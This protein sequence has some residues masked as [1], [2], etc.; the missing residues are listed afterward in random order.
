MK[1]F[2]TNLKTLAVVGVAALAVSCAEAYDDTDLRNEVAK[3]AERVQTLEDRWEE[4]VAALRAL[5]DEKVAL[6]EVKEDGAW[7]FTLSDGKTL[8]L[9]PEYAE[10][11]LTLITEG[12]VKYWAKVEGNVVTAL[13]DAQGNKVAFNGAPQ[14]Q[15]NAEGVVEVSVDG[16][17]SWIATEAKS[18]ISA[19]DVEENVA[20]VTLH[21]GE[22]LKFALYEQVN[23]NVNGHALFVAPASSEK[24]TMTLDGIVE[25]LP[26]VAPK[27]WSVEVDGLVVTVT[28]PTEV[29]EVQQGGGGIG[30]LSTEGSALGAASGAVKLLA[31]SKEGKSVVATLYV[32]A[33]VSGAQSLKVMGENLVITN[34]ATSTNRWGDV[35]PAAM[36]IVAF[37]AGE[38]T[39]ESFLAANQ[40]YSFPYGTYYYEE[41]GV[42]TVAVSEI[43]ASLC[44]VEK[45]ERGAAYT[46]LA[47]DPNA[48]PLEATGV[49][50][51]DYVATYTNVELAG[52]TFKDININV[53]VEGYD[54][55]KL[56][57]YNTKYDAFPE[58]D[59]Q[60]W[61]YY[62]ERADWGVNMTSNYS[63]SIFDVV[64]DI[65]ILAN[66]A[67]AIYVLPMS[68][69]KS[70]ADYKWDDVLG[71]YAFKTKSYASGGMLQPTLGEAY[72]EWSG[73]LME[74]DYQNFYAGVTAPEGAYRTHAYYY[75]AEQLA[76]FSNEADLVADIV[77][78][79]SIITG[80][81]AGTIQPDAALNPGTT[82][83]VAAVTVDAD[84]K[85]GPVVK[86]EYS[87]KALEY[88]A[89]TIEFDAWNLVAPSRTMKTADSSYTFSIKVNGGELANTYMN[90]YTLNEYS[91]VEKMLEEPAIDVASDALWGTYVPLENLAKTED[92][93]YAP[94]GSVK[95]VPY[96][97][98]TYAPS[99]NVGLAYGKE[100]L[101][102]VFGVDADG[103]PTNVISK[104]F[105][106]FVPLTLVYQ[107]DAKWAASRPTVTVGEKTT[108]MTYYE[109]LKED[110]EMMLGWGYTEEELAMM[111]Q[112]NPDSYKEETKNYPFRQDIAFTVTPGPG[113]VECVLRYDDQG[114]TKNEI[115]VRVW[116]DKMISDP[117][118]VPEGGL[119]SQ[120]MHYT[121]TEETTFVAQMVATNSD[122]H[123]YVTWRDADGNWYE[124]TMDELNAANMPDELAGG[125]N[126]G[127]MK[128]NK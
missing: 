38:Y 93:L 48:W 24:V 1:R 99:K 30:P 85:Y 60:M 33:S 95:A 13:T 103:K 74:A 76:N 41:N 105:E 47:F 21:S 116:V 29:E 23:F 120:H 90:L 106:T 113:A 71:P 78:K 114:Y 108:A 119:I 31:V 44:E 110:W 54:S 61:Q 4:E 59:F 27:G 127:V 35:M 65:D 2:F 107:D 6:A 7:Q 92:G 128:A 82:M 16:G 66:Q 73:E 91:I 126:A 124:A 100:Y 34:Y 51:A 69:L 46:F 50:R 117:E 123:V 109:Y 22:V 43:L 86:K 118:A 64:G 56:V 40:D 89:V 26:L 17:A 8:T 121:F 36:A 58:E 12:G 125:G 111:G 115:A 122:A 84:G 49:M 32:N 80:A 45:I 101:L 11:G 25:V 14:V 18:L 104:Q 9:Y 87:T 96:K 67:Y 79:G 94:A 97:G 3:L 72:N 15:V 10:N 63:G 42:Q 83:T 39:I 5:I 52:A 98:G 62:G 57:V 88:S 37:P 19:I 55:Y 53:T 112:T 70:S 20:N 77:A 75:T 68:I 102:V 28:A 81:K